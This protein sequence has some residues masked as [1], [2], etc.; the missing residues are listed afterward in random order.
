ML[1][2]PNSAEVFIGV[3]L[4]L[5]WIPLGLAVLAI[6]QVGA[7]PLRLLELVAGSPGGPRVQPSDGVALITGAASGIGEAITRELASEGFD[8]V[9]VDRD[10]RGM[11]ALADELRIPATVRCEVCDLSSPAAV[12]ALCERLTDEIRVCVLV[13]C[14]GVLQVGPLIEQPPAAL[15]TL[16]LLNMYAVTML[17]RHFGARMASAGRGHILNIASTVAFF[18]TPGAA[19]YSASKAYLLAF[20]ETLSYE[21]RRTGVSA[22]AVCPGAARTRLFQTAGMSG[23]LL[24]DIWPMSLVVFSSPEL[25]ARAAV[26]G[27][28]ARRR[29]VFTDLGQQLIYALIGDANTRFSRQWLGQFV[30]ATRRSS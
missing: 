9:L 21:L 6:K 26:R 17:S 2:L 3:F 27:A 19:A 11:L 10:E 12:D 29:I 20:T 7:L 1:P 5:L 15:A 4:H 24:A 8:L 13:N 18:P 30:W 25:I 14:A 22:T 28:F 16:C 23:R